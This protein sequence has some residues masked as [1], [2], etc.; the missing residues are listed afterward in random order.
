[1][2]PGGDVLRHPGLDSLSRGHWRGFECGVVLVEVGSEDPRLFLFALFGEPFLAGLGM[3]LTMAGPTRS[4]RV[5]PEM[6]PA[7]VPET[8][9]D[10]NGNGRPHHIAASNNLSN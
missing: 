7:L 4:P 3:A 10:P 5:A 9:N 2:H 1:M 8:Q 6:A